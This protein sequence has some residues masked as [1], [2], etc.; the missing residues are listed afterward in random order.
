MKRSQLWVEGAEWVS[1]LVRGSSG[2]QADGICQN[3]LEGL[4]RAHRPPEFEAGVRAA[5]EA[6]L[7]KV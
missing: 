2:E 4:E 3:I 6:V 5:V 7:A 1:E